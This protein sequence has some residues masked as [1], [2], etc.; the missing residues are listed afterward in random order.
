MQT[1]QTVFIDSFFQNYDTE[2]VKQLDFAEPTMT[3]Q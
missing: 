2:I 3:L 1:V